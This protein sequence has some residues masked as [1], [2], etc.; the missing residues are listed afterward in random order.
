V[1]DYVAVGSLDE[2]AP[3]TMRVVSV[4]GTDLI[5]A[6]TEGRLYAFGRECS[7]MGAELEDGLLEGHTVE[8]PIHD[9]IFDITTGEITHGP[10]Y[11]PIPVYGVR[12]ADSRVE[13]DRDTL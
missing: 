2:F 1:A 7:H 4:D 3:G 9:S 6:N 8:C 11:G 10:G 13:V 5:I 12:V